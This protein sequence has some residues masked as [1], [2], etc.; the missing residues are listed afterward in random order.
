LLLIS[1]LNFNVIFSTLQEYIDPNYPYLIWN[2]PT[3]SKQIKDSTLLRYN[4]AFQQHSVATSNPTV[5]PMSPSTTELQIARENFKYVIIFFK[6]L[7]S[8]R[9]Q[10]SEMVAAMYCGILVVSGR[11]YNCTALVLCSRVTHY[12]TLVDSK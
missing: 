4:P 3:T 10:I 11:F 12:N 2:Q 6:L 7:L 5:H 8:F 9:I 1:L